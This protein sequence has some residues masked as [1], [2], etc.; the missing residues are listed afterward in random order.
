MKK[1]LLFLLILLLLPFAWLYLTG[2]DFILTGIART[3]LKGNPT[4]NID[5]HQYFK[6]RI[7]EAGA[8]TPWPLSAEYGKVHLSDEFSSYLE[9]ND[10]VAYLVAHHGEL[11][12]ESY[13]DG[14]NDRSKTNSFSMAKTVVTLLLG[15]AIQDGYIESIDQKLVDF[16]PEFQDD[17]LGSEA[18]IGSLSSMSSG[19]NWDESYYNPFSPT[20]QLYYGDDVVD[21]LVNRDFSHEVDNY[22]Y[23]SSASTQ[24]LAILISRALQAKNP[25]MTLSAYLSNKIWKPLG[26]NADALWHLDDSGMELGYCCLNTNAQNF[27]KLGQLMLQNGKWMEQEIVDSS[28]IY[29]MHTPKFVDNYGYA[30]W[31]GSY[32]GEPYYYFRGHLGQFIIVVPQHDLIVVRLGKTTGGGVVEDNLSIYIKEALS[33]VGEE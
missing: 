18:T 23:Y 3:Y 9:K 10:A 14:Y 5:D 11:V 2:N 16:L 15:I 28:F 22:F 33:L 19:Y 21:F 12:C 17:P 27:A 4:A 30:T 29:L 8:E 7:I 31:L 13:F 20:V 24:L 6:T 32:E 25:E 1:I 26:M